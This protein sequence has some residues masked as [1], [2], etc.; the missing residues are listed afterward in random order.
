MTVLPLHTLPPYPE[1]PLCHS[2][3]QEHKTES[4]RPR[5]IPLNLDNEPEMSMALGRLLRR[6]PSELAV[7][8]D[9]DTPPSRPSR[10][11]SIRRQ[12]PSSPSTSYSIQSSDLEP[13]TSSR[14]NPSRPTALIPKSML[15]PST[16][17]AYAVTQMGMGAGMFF[18]SGMMLGTPLVAV[19]S[20][21][22]PK[23]SHS[24]KRKVATHR[25]EVKPPD[26][27]LA[28]LP[29]PPLP[30]SPLTSTLTRL[31]TT[32]RGRPELRSHPDLAVNVVP[33]S[34]SSPLPS[35]AEPNDHL[36]NTSSH[37]C[38]HT[39]SPSSFIS[40]TA[41]TSSESSALRTSSTSRKKLLSIPSSEAPTRSLSL[42]QT[43]LSEQPP[44]A[45]PLLPITM[46]PRS[47]TP[48]PTTPTPPVP[49]RGRSR[50]PCP[51]NSP[52][53]T[54]LSSRSGTPLPAP[55]PS[56]SP[57]SVP[58]PLATEPAAPKRSVR[59]ASVPRAIAAPDLREPVPALPTMHDPRATRI[60]DTPELHVVPA[61]PGARGALTF[62]ERSEIESPADEFGVLTFSDGSSTRAHTLGARPSPGEAPIGPFNSPSWR[63]ASSA[64]GD[65]ISR[66]S[67]PALSLESAHS[68]TGH[69]LR[70]GGGLFSRRLF[71]KRAPVTSL[72]D[73]PAASG[74]ASSLATTAAEGSDEGHSGLP[75][76][77]TDV[78]YAPSVE[79]VD[80]PED[81]RVLVTV[82][83]PEGDWRF[84]NVDSVM[85]MLRDMKSTRWKKDTRTGLYG[86]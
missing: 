33:T 72:Y 67:S 13:L 81:A 24:A 8:I 86:F 73:T 52:Q 7:P 50:S 64:S 21:T 49:R 38:T 4:F 12:P 77:S 6:K 57:R 41:I 40:S 29:K 54:P 35:V 15:D 10:K 79:P 30:P 75:R 58:R 59:S 14:G 17:N 51:A 46:P 22:P 2:P 36:P 55:P 3:Q 78:T 45:L 19:A 85:P 1:A 56:L 23:K 26:N 16:P 48:L 32:P 63:A 47:R 71:R 27:E 43:P 18:G 34:A 20:P 37:G 39:S 61:T 5:P 70:S 68:D 28:A 80:F 42:A 83:T 84:T 74:S 25:T 76:A 31:D 82:K 60:R 65:S 9:C 69:S 62:A 44:S 66:A 53:S 11:L